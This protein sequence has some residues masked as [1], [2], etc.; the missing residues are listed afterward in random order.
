MLFIHE[1]SENEI[2]LKFGTGEGDIHSIADIA[3]WIMHVTSQLAGLL[4]LKGAKEAAELEKRIHYGAAPELMDLL[5]IRGIGRVRA[6]K[7][8]KA[9]FKSSAEL[10]GVDPEKVAVLLGPKI[11][12]RIFKQ[13][14]SKEA[15]SGIIESEPPEK[16]PYSGQ[17][18][19]SD[20]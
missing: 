7:L 14:K 13:I 9:G 18:T 15:F 10:A 16:S 5:D 2:C 4:D 17:K 6:R 11:A 1:K 20:Y 12:D 3:E 8:Y 19:I